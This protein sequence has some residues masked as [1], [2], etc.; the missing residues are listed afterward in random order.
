[1][2]ETDKTNSTCCDTKAIWYWRLFKYKPAAA[3][4]LSGTRVHEISALKNVIQMVLAQTENVWRVSCW[5]TW[6]NV[7]YVTS[8]DTE[9]W[10]P[11]C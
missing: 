1:M 11:V 3:C 7:H 2:H 5:A 10:I 9:W 8:P 4:I 6:R